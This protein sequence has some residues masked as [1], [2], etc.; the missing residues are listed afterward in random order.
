MQQIE[1]LPRSS[2]GVLTPLVRAIVE[3]INTHLQLVVV[4]GTQTHDLPARHAAIQQSP[5]QL[6]RV[7]QRMVPSLAAED[8]HAVCRV[9]DEH[10][11]LPQGRVECRSRDE[12]AAAEPV[13]EAVLPDLLGT[14]HV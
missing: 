7:Q 14:Q 11:T 1:P 9:S 12:Y 4:I 6:H 3:G 5:G 8:R 10:D 13:V 2:D